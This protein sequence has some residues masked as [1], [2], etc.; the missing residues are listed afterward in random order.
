VASVKKKKIANAVE[1]RRPSFG[2]ILLA[3]LRN[4]CLGPSAQKISCGY[5]TEI[6]KPPHSVCNRKPQCDM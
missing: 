1:S 6:G 3:V 2:G 4:R 5:L